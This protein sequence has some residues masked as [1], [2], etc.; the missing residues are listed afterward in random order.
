MARFVVGLILGIFL[1]ALAAA[2]EPTLPAELRVAL[3]NVTTLV[4]RG[5]EKAAQ[6][7]DQAAGRVADR[8][9]RAGQGTPNQDGAPPPTRPATR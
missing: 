7:V 1:G 6:S 9:Q 8:T 5:T 4:A 3:A 2:Y